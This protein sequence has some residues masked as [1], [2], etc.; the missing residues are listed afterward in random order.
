[1]HAAFRLHC[2][3]LEAHHFNKEKTSSQIVEELAI[4]V[5]RRAGV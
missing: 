3:L 1:V 4:A 5:H 2:L